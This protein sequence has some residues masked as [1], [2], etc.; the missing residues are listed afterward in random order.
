MS[1][2][3]GDSGIG[4]DQDGITGPWHAMYVDAIPKACTEYLTTSY[5]R[6]DGGYGRDRKCRISFRPSRR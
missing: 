3:V 5:S 6:A 4:I 1:Y 2:K